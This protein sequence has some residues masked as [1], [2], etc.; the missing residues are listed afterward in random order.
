[1]SWRHHFDFTWVL[2][3]TAY[4][5][6]DAIQRQNVVLN[7]DK[8]SIFCNYF[9]IQKIKQRKKIPFEEV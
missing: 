2:L 1:M 4:T 3:Q 6:Q 5:G 8:M 9:N 7:F